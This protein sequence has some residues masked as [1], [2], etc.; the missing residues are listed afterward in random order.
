MT[1]LDI[2]GTVVGETALAIKAPCMV[3]TA[4]SNITLSGVQMIDGVAVGNHSERVL[5]KDQ[6]VATQ[7]GI[8]IAGTGAW[9]LAADFTSNN[10]VAL[11]T[12]VLVTSGN[13]NAGLLFE[14]TCADNPVVIGTSLIVFSSLGVNAAQAATSTTSTTIGAGAKTFTIQ[15]GKAFAA[16]Q[17]V[18]IYETSAP[19]TNSMLATVTSYS[20]TSL[21]VNVVATA[22]S[23]THADWSIVLTN[24][25]AG[26]G[27]QPPVGTGNVTGPGSSTM[28]HVATFADATG[29]VLQD[30]GALVPAANTVTAAMLQASALAIGANMINGTFVFSNSGN[31]LTIAVK[32]LAGADPSSG[33]PVYFI[34]R[35]P[36]SGLYVILPRTSALSVTIPSGSTLG[37]SNS[38]PFRIWV[39]VLYTGSPLGELAVINCLSGTSIFPLGSWN[40]T[41]IN[42]TA[43]GA[44]ANSAQVLYSQTSRAG[45]NASILGFFSYEAGATLAAAGTWNANPGRSDIYM[46]GVLLPGQV[47][48]DQFSSTGAL[49]TTTNTYAVSDTPPAPAGGTNPV[50]QAVIPSS[51]ANVLDIEGQIILGSTGTAGESNTAYITQDGGTTPLATVSMNNATASSE[52]QALRCR[53]RMLAAQL[54]ST[55]FK[56]YGSGTGGTTNVNGATGGRIFGGTANTF[57]SVKEI[58]A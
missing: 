16:N 30:G 52:P 1:T 11:G 27:I 37:T 13:T 3:A 18:V 45:A 23:G 15:A 48:Q 57:I 17:Y 21:V 2:R 25:S 47:I 10:N 5:V 53:T 51:S 40:G 20:G 46:P 34:F 35:N 8:Y 4:G 39:M 33:D 43:F 55:T 6:S 49:S 19:A 14:Q 12:M 58:Q 7:N 41:I 38:T 31:A 28:G 50:S 22:G 24:S 9:V 54:T 42:S 32:T 36:G 29:K 56:L 44:G 26:A